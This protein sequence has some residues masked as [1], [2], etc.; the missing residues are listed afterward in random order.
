MI[1]AIIFIIL[2]L[3][4]NPYIDFSDEHIII[5]Y[6]TLFKHERKYIMFR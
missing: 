6:S 3:R 5:W 4:I 2:F 1:L